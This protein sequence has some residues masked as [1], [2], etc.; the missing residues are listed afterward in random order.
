MMVSQTS[1]YALHILGFLARN[2][3]RLVRGEEIAAAT[4]IPSNYLSKILSQLRKHGLVDSQKGWGG[5][6]ILRESALERPIRDVLQ[7]IEGAEG[8]QRNDCIF[9]LPACDANNPCPL[10]SHWEKIRQTYEEMLGNTRIGD[11][12]VAS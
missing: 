5:G 1:R 9:G 7:I 11:L 6:F 8:I 10:H 2:P 4:G 3:G 12:A